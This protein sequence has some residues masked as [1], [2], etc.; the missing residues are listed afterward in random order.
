[1]AN[2]SQQA[3]RARSPSPAASVA[4]IVLML[5][6]QCV[7]PRMSRPQRGVGDF[8][9][10]TMHSRIVMNWDR[11]K[12]MTWLSYLDGVGRRRQFRQTQFTPAR[13]PGST[14]S[15]SPQSIMYTHTFTVSSKASMAASKPSIM[16]IQRRFFHQGLELTATIILGLVV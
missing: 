16:E 1:M 12:S 9:G 5:Y 3:F 2:A 14:S 15:G 4:L 6:R 13:W 7:L 8:D 11:S 10:L